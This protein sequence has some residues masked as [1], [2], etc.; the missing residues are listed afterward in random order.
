[1]EPTGDEG[2]QPVDGVVLAGDPVA[3][4][5]IGRHERLETLGVHIQGR[6]LDLCESLGRG[7]I[8]H[9]E[10]GAGVQFLFFS[11]ITSNPT[12]RRIERVAARRFVPL[13]MFSTR[14]DSQPAM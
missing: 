12:K 1:V 7:E 11:V 5:A 14:T 2:E 3:E 13:W 9:V 10:Q 8:R 4:V 6:A